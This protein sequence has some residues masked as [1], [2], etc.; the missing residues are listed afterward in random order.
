MAL[1]ATYVDADTFTV[2]GDKTADFVADRKVRCDCGV[3]GYKYCVVS[4]S[5]YGDPNTT[6]DLTADSD[7]LT[8]NLTGV[9]WSVVKPGTAGN[10]SLHDHVDEDAGGFPL[11][12]ILDEKAA[13]PSSPASGY[14]RVFARDSGGA[15]TK[16]SDGN[17]YALAWAGG[18]VLDLIDEP[19]PASW[20]HKDGATGSVYGDLRME[21]GRDT[22]AAGTKAITFQQAFST[23]LEVFLIDKTAA[24]AMYPSAMGTTGFTANGNATDTFG[25]LA[26][27][28]D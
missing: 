19:R 12:V 4:A 22:L 6:V 15:F 20:Q 3:D 16:D 7:D 25:W 27:G 17:V 14:R 18:D 23:L 5:S 28:V 9:D 26:V 24:Q 13:D 8:N 21:W 10:I 2:V 11:E 1:V